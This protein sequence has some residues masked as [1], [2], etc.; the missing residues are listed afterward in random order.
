[1]AMRA[2][3]RQTSL[4]FPVMITALSR[5]AGVPRDSKREIEVTPSS[6]TD[7]WRIEAKYTREVADRR[8]EAPA[9]TLP[10]VDV[11]SLPAEESLPTLASGLQDA[12]DVD[13]P[14][15][16]PATTCD[17][18]RDEIVVTESNAETNEEQIQIQ[19]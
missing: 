8:R 4:P 16:P 19:E 18:H 12:N 2:K 13:D 6:S 15:I 9:D 7:I 11:A 17:V 14:E 3:H 1:M 10:E 5:R